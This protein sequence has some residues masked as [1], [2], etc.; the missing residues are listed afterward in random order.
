MLGPYE[1]ATRALR[2]MG[3]AQIRPALL[4]RGENLI[5]AGY[6]PGPR[7]REMLTL[8]EDAQLE[9]AVQTSAEALALVR[10]QFGAPAS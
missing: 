10:E 4:L 6:R 9:G 7:F 8:A 3:E 2:E 1:T 5:A